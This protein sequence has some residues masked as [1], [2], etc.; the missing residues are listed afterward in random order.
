MQPCGAEFQY[1]QV[2]EICHDE[3]SLNSSCKTKSSNEQKRKTR[4]S[5][6]LQN[7]LHAQS[8]AHYDR[9]FESR[10]HVKFQKFLIEYMRSFDCL[11][12]NCE[13]ACRKLLIPNY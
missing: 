13:Q 3:T 5:R 10:L 7:S 12:K 6:Y 4:P 1:N 8:I 11:D 9:T 2:F